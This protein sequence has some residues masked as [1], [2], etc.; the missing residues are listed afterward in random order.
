MNLNQGL[1]AILIAL[2]ATIAIAHPPAVYA[3]SAKLIPL[4]IDSSAQLDLS[5]SVASEFSAAEMT[6]EDIFNLGWDKFRKGDYQGAI[7]AFDRAIGLNPNYADA[8]SRRGIARAALKDNQGAIADYN[9][10]LKLDPKNFI[11]YIG[12]GNIRSASG[13]KQGALADF[14]QALK[15]DPNDAKL[16][17]NRGVIRYQLEDKQGALADFNQALKIDPNDVLAYQNRG[18]IHSELGDKQS[19]IKDFQ[20][21]ADLYQQKGDKDNYQQLLNRIRT[22][23]GTE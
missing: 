17:V 16:Y 22:I 19:A 20:K 21:A 15:I 1:P 12:R 11:A 9:Q 6:V 10:A 5:V 7:E 18:V 2:T 4:Q 23:Q 13:D 8:Y 3:K 14:N